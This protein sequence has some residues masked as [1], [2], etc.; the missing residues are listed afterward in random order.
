MVE[1]TNVYLSEIIE[2]SSLGRLQKK[3]L[4]H[5]DCLYVT[6]ISERGVR[7]PPKENVPSSEN[8]FQTNCRSVI[9][10]CLK[11]LEQH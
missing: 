5:N 8:Y 11:K 3:S 4:E 6:S 10:M 7:K 2:T 1:I 9:L